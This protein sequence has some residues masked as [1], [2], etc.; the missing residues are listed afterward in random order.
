MKIR[1][2]GAE[3]DEQGPLEL[4][5][6]AA[7]PEGGKSRLFLLLRVPEKDRGLGSQGG[8]PT[9]ALISRPRWPHPNGG[10]LGGLGETS[11]GSRAG[12][13]ERFAA[14]VASGGNRQRH[15]PGE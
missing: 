15:L 1:G 7:G 14:L 12:C 3:R 2:F 11:G 8:W 6:G 4:G 5:L 9:A 13:S 10:S